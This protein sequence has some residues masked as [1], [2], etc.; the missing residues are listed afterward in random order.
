MQ[1]IVLVG[2]LGTRLR[3]LTANTPKQML[4]VLDRPMIE[5]VVGHLADH[6][7]TRLVL[8]V[9]FRPEAFLE[10]YPDGKCAG[11]PLHYAVEPEPLDTAGAIR[12][13]ADHAEIDNTFLVLNGDILTDL[14][15]SALSKSH[16]A[17]GALGTIALT[18]VDDPSRYGV[19]SLGVDSRVL[20]FVEKPHRDE[21]PSRWVNAGTY[22]LEPDVLKRIAVDRRVSIEREV[23]PAMAD[24][25]SLWALCSDAYW[26]DAGTPETYLR[27]QTDLI[28]GSR[29]RLDPIAANAVVA[30][31]ATVEH[32][33]IMGGAV[34]GARA[35]VCDAVLM[36]GAVVESGAVVTNS[37]V[38][39]GS[40]VGSGA[41]VTALS[42]IGGGQLVAAGAVVVGAR[43]P[44][45]G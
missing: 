21:A 37:V 4:P 23:F 32:S 33:V 11:M 2:G 22:V 42:L 35:Q 41:S 29:G 30:G 31:D 12:F 34:I 16:Q 44:D 13:A 43:I 5:H 39:P 8:S 15:I 27:A 1:A 14:D 40:R 19:V 28:D 24:E 6:G 25:G 20:G 18:E 17:S 26:L 45:E 7:V 10:A 36:E 38:G 9:G 3:P